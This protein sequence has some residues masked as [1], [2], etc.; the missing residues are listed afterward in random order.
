MARRPRNIG[1][2]SLISYSFPVMAIASILH[3]ISGVLLFL[4]TPFLLWALYGSLNSPS[5]FHALQASLTSPCAKLCIWVFLSALVY[6]LLAGFKHL[7]MDIGFCEELNSSKF[8]SWLVIL[9][10]LIAVVMLGVW[11]W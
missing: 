10:S 1:L 3:R 9:L 2:G 7:L 11:L 8:A 5:C 4:F 6:H